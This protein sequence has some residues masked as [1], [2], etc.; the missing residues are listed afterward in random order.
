MQ[1]SGLTEIILLIYTSAIWSQYSVFSHPE[2]SQ[3]ALLGV[4]KALDCER[5]GIQFDPVSSL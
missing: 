2:F 4:A 5:A 1:E 3:G